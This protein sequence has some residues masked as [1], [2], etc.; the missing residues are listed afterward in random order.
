MKKIYALLLI[1]SA[2]GLTVSSQVVINE[3]Y[4]GGGNAGAVFKNDFIELYNN[5]NA[6]VSLTGWSVQYASAAGTTWQVTNLAGSIAANGYYLI[7]QAQGSLGT[8]DLPVPDAT[9]TIPMSGTA[10][11][12][13]LVNNQIAL[14]GTCPAGAQIIDKVGFGVTANCVETAAAPAPSN[15]TSIQRTPIGTDTQNNS[16]DFTAGSPSPSNSGGSDVTPPSVVTFSPANAATGIATSFT[17]SATFSESVVKA[18]SGTITIKKLSDN[19]I[20]Q[21]IDILNSSVFI[22]GAILNFPVNGLALNT[23]YYVEIT[24]GA[25]KDIALNN[26]A[27]ITGS[28]T[29]AFTT[30]ATAPAGTL[31]TT[32]N[33]NTCGPSIQAGFT[34]YSVNGAEVWGC[35]AFGRDP[36]NPS[37]TAAFESAVQING[38][39]GGTN[40]LNEDWLISPSFDLSATAYPLLSFWSRIAFNGAP[41]QL[42]VS[43]DYPGTGD[44]KAYTWTDLNGRFPS[45]QTTTNAWTLSQNINLSAYKSTRTYIAFVYHSTPDDGA[46]WTLDDILVSISATPPP[47][48]L[49]TS[50]TDILFGAVTVSTPAVKTFTFVGNDL[51]GGVILNAGGSFLLSKTNGGFSNA[52]SYTQ[53]EANNIAQ[54]VYVQFLPAQNNANYTGTITVSTTDIANIILNV[55][56]NSIDPALTLEVVNWNLEWFGTPNA[57]FGPPNKNL[58]EANIK[59]ITKNIG[60]DLFAFVEVVSEPRLQNVVAELNAM[61][62]ANTY[63]YVISDYGSHTNPFENSPP[64]GPLTEAQKAAFVYKTAV[65]TPIGTPGPLVT[66]GVNTAADLNNPAFNYFASGRYPYM[67]NASVTLGGVVKQVRFVLIHAKA[68][69]S[70]TATSYARRKK[71]A[72]TL[73]Y[74]LNSLY[75]NDNIIFLGD[76]N[77]D[78]DQSIT[79][80]FTESSYSTFNTDAA[81]FSSPT[82]ALSQAGK[83]STVSYNDMID[84]VTVS[85]EMLP[86]YMPGTASVL[87]DVTSLVTNY[88]GTTTDHYPIFTRYAFDAGILPVTLISFTVTKQNK[89]AV[90]NWK[91]S[92]EINSKLFIAERSTDSRNWV[93]AGTVNA[94][95]NSIATNAYT[96]TDNSPANGINY[97]R[98]KQVDIDGKFRYSQVRTALF[99]KK[100]TIVVAPNPAK[101]LVNI[102]LDKFNNGPVTINIMDAAG[103]HCY[104][105]VTTAGTFQINSGQFAKGT[106]F[107]KVINGKEIIIQKLVVE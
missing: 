23:A 46:R 48:S 45:L 78:L 26:F 21:T 30:T 102:K 50:T 59:T 29:W 100:T 88:A 95:G 42:K 51:T 57:A 105:A 35:T 15:T 17:A 56:G 27:G 84:H 52:I 92:Q 90:L 2:I 14:A 43:T 65:I 3:V 66:N 85:N 31:G 93:T 19:S 104:H 25:F 13:A 8:T 77:D 37:G 40:V 58:Q 69:T 34:T 9:G 94:A 76:F 24:S 4:G 44:P 36:A 81:N 68:N 1:F 64:R 79:A 83:K 106:Y 28:S 10:G 53:A 32:Y 96:L 74:T 91:T 101:G 107:I 54:T 103:K 87:T 38:F 49:S 12:I 75:P 71:G 7:Q 11:K 97:Y 89:V 39:T 18:A 16:A 5:S 82:L 61:Y 99:E 67:M 72:D 60:A 6:P 41:L 73:N 63:S 47:A 80:G 33:F 20:V 22:S 55:T 86:Y 70:P 62:G 98:L